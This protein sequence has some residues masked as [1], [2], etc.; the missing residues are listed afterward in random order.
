MLYIS[1]VC[2]KKKTDTFSLSSPKCFFK[3]FTSANSN[4]DRCGKQ[5]GAIL[6]WNVHFAHLGGG[7]CSSETSGP[8][9]VCGS[10][11]MRCGENVFTPL[12]VLLTPISAHMLSFDYF[13]QTFLCNTGA[14]DIVYLF[15]WPSEQTRTDL[16]LLVLFRLFRYA[17]YK[18]QQPALQLL[19]VL[20]LSNLA[21]VTFVASF[22]GNLANSILKYEINVNNSTWFE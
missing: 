5:N 20:C 14:F 15:S 13:S 22:E 10:L 17:E 7:F 21:T 8:D 4:S 2:V 11:M 3:G 9:G 6:T 18:H 16:I 1:Q 19:L 12:F